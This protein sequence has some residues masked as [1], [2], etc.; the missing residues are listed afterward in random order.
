MKKKGVQ[1]FFV[2]ITD[3]TKA[4]VEKGVSQRK[5]ECRKQIVFLS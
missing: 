2:F 1:T 3:C 5:Q 4:Q